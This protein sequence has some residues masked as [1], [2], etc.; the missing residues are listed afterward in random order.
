MGLEEE[1]KEKIER[2]ILQQLERYANN[3]GLNAPRVTPDLLDSIIENEAYYVFPES[4]VTICLL[5]LKNG[6][7]VTGES[8]CA[9]PNNFD[10]ELGRKISRDNAKNKIWALEGYLLKQRLFETKEA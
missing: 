5:K 2:I 8:A 1:I 10:D 3:V 6:F 9:S 7:S 4:T